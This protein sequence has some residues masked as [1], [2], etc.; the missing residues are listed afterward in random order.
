MANAVIVVEQ[1]G[2]GVGV[3]SDAVI[4]R[5]VAGHELFYYC[6]DTNL[7]MSGP[8]HFRYGR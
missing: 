3:D 1:P 5:L 7:L 8:S 2:A 6:L 4:D